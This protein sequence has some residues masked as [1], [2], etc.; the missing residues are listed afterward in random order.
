[1]ASPEVYNFNPGP[2]TLPREVIERAQEEF[3]DFRNAGYGI[4]EASHRGPL[5][6]D[7]IGRA[8]STIRELL[9]ISEDY[10]VLFLQGG[11][12]L[13]FAMAP[14]NLM[15]PGKQAL[16]ADTGEWTRKAIDE[17][18]LFGETK[19]VYEGKET[20]YKR[21]GDCSEWEVDS[22]ASYVYVCSNNTIHGTQ[23]HFFP[24]TNGV[25]LVADMS[26]DIMSR[27]ID[28]DQFGL[29][30]A[31]AQKNLGPAGVTLVI[32]RK[33]LAER[34]GT[35]VPTML[36]YSTH[37]SKGSL[38]NTPPVFAI[39]MVGLV[40]EW[41]RDQGGVAAIEKINM[42][43]SHNLYEFIDMSIFYQ[44]T[45]EPGD[46]SK[47]NICFRLPEEELEGR[48]V[49]EAEAA[50]LIGLKGHRSVGGIRASLY[51][52]MPLAGVSRLLDFM[53]EFEE[54]HG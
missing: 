40:A 49:K 51:N 24:E 43:K 21:I 9:G 54:Q 2:A 29:I 14:M 25:P 7:V 18:G 3:A 42:V 23:Y 19:V 38:F 44:G 5:F 12:S 39:Y 1:M 36:R 26:S 41:I 15:L 50:G 17:A 31:G 53:D 6:E 11:A 10:A 8:D 47:M 20:E 48:F 13:Q 22:D 52:A 46:R 32:L 27:R 37:I 33:D 28:V 16:Y 34:A 45:A 35:S 30:F 4:V